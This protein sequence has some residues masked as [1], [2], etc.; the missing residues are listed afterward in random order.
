VWSPPA[1]ALAPSPSFLRKPQ[2]S[3]PGGG[4]VSTLL[5]EGD[6]V[7]ASRPFLSI[8]Q[9]KSCRADR[10]APPARPRA[11]MCRPRPHTPRRAVGSA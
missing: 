8:I 9:P 11:R 3:V 4:H 5:V 6:V 1:F 7:V 10:A 2:W